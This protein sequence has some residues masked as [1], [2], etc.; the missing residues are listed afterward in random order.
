MAREFNWIY[1]SSLQDAQKQ[2]LGGV[3]LKTLQIPQE[4]TCARVSY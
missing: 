3:L 4:N 1:T 2:S